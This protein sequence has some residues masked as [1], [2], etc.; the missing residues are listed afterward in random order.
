MILSIIVLVM[1]SL[2]LK[3]EDGLTVIYID[4]K[5]GNPIGYSNQFKSTKQFVHYLISLHN[6]FQGGSLKIKEEYFV[7]FYKGKNNSSINK[8]GTT[9]RKRIKGSSPENAYKRLMQKEK[10]YLYLKELIN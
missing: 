3:K 9:G 1:R 4:L 5:S 10:G 8:T 7:I 6:E 2:S